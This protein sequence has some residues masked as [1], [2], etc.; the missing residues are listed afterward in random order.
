MAFYRSQRS[1][2]A[3]L[4][5]KVKALIPAYCDARVVTNGTITGWLNSR[6]EYPAAPYTGFAYSVHS[7]CELQRIPTNFFDYTPYRGL[8]GVGPFSYDGTIDHPHGWT[9]EYTVAGGPFFPASRTNW[10]TTDYGW[11]TLKGVLTNL[12]YTM[13][14]GLSGNTTT[15][16]KDGSSY[17][18]TNW[19][20]A[21]SEAETNFYAASSGSVFPWI[22]S[23]KDNL[24]GYY[25]AELHAQNIVI[26]N[27][28]SIC[29]TNVLPSAATIYLLTG[30][31]VNDST[32]GVTIFPQNYDPFD[33]GYTNQGAWWSVASTNWDWFSSL[34]CNYGW[35]EVQ[36]GARNN[37]GGKWKWDGV[38]VGT[39]NKPEWAADAGLGNRFYRGFTM[40]YTQP[41]LSLFLNFYGATNGFQ[42]R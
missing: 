24:S 22:Y 14:P 29:R 38:V 42:Y 13:R 23:V 37:S 31:I 32:N 10:Y 39:T 18:Q 1:N 17:F 19:A 35:Q 5:T 20:D 6:T 15:Y 16:A 7:F 33:T 11:D 27:L 41:T 3:L 34:G 8:D 28:A 30:G 2:L 40:G 25:I 21:V 4:K 12:Q 26:S 36:E 9:N